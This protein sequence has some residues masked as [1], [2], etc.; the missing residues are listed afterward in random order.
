MRI[1]HL[2]TL[3]QTKNQPMWMH[4]AIYWLGKDIYNYSKEFYHLKGNNIIKTNK[5]P[6]FYY[7]DLI[8]YMKTQNSNIPN[9]QNKTK[10]IYQSIL[11]KGSQNHNLFGEK[12]W[13][14]EIKNLNFKN[15]W[16]NTYFSYT[17]PYA[18][19]LLYKFLHYAIKTN[20]FVFTISRDKTGLTPTC[21]YCNT[22][23]DNIHLFTTCT[24][25]KKIWKY[26][27]PTNEKLT[28]KQ[29]TPRQHI[30]T[31]STNNLNSKNKK[32]IIT[33]TQLIMYE[34][35]TSRNNLNYDKTQ[36]SQETIITKI[37]T[38]IRNILTAHYKL[39]KLNQTLPTFQKLF[40][41]NNTIAKTHNSKLKLVLQ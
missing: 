26:F 20:N 16:T 24:R 32:L 30:V 4:I 22:K 3:K 31:L 34:I 11:E 5:M 38:Q 39:H 33:L 21:N 2:I 40:C 18:K 10:I 1:K 28:K 9:L 19:D 7:Q 14:D 23:E 41:I 8:H 35:W 36:L 37:L 12:K 15:I 27:Q 13:K 6:P 29:Y 25:V 17:Q